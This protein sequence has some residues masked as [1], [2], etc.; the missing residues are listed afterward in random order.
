MNNENI[1]RIYF[2]LGRVLDI[3]HSRGVLSAVGYLCL[4]YFPAPRLVP[5][6]EAVQCLL[7]GWVLG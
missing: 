5:S 4:A 6:T 2:E 1:L 7:Y 3:L